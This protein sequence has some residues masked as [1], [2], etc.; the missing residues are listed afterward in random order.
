MRASSVGVEAADGLLVCSCSSIIDEMSSEILVIKV[1]LL[2]R[3]VSMLNNGVA[4][5]VALSLAFDV[6]AT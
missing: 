3:L 5:T 4:V 6:S 2:I 1:V